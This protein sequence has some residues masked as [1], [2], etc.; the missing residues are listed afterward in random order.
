MGSTSLSPLSDHIHGKTV[1]TGMI[2]SGAAATCRGR[3]HFDGTC[4]G[5]A[6]V[7]ACAH[8]RPRSQK[9]GNFSARRVRPSSQ[10]IRH[11]MCDR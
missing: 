9:A 7:A 2:V 8:D 11:G 1:K 10:F 5:V 6:T 4:R 3:I